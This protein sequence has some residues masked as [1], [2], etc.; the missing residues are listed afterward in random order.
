MPAT[1][2][3]IRIFISSPGDVRPERDALEAVISDDLQRTLGRQHNLYLEPLRWENLA[4]PGL[5][6]IQSQV[7][8]QM[9]AYDIFVGIFWKRFGTPTAKHESGSEEEFRDAYA[10]WEEDNDRPVMMYF[11][12]RE[13]NISLDTDP[14]K[15]MKQLQQAQKVKAFREEIGQKGL[16][17][18]YKEVD[19]FK[20]EIGRH[21][22]DAILSLLE[23][24]DFEKKAP[25]P[26]GE[27]LK[28]AQ[29]VV[30][31][32]VGQASGGE[33]KGA[34]FHHHHYYAS[35]QASDEVEESKDPMKFYLTALK[36]ECEVLPLAT[37]GGKAGTGQNITLNEVYISLG[38]KTPE[39]ESR[40]ANPEEEEKYLT[41][42]EASNQSRLVVL[43]GGP[44][45]G[46]STFVKELTANLA[47]KRLEEPTGSVPVF[48]TLRD[49]APRLGAIKE[50]LAG[51][52]EDKRRRKL[53][54]V[55]LD[56]AIA[57]LETLNALE[58]RRTGQRGLYRRQGPPGA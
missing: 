6:D 27:T 28:Q 21:L 12:E 51:L 19:E 35:S 37:L 31:I 5:G 46:K 58:A 22:H 32:H 30:N 38:T 20:I 52:Q 4:R 44:G 13:A 48:I 8:E 26:T 9:G 17:W 55:V 50:K 49:L 25:E 45:S 7:S 41:A 43:V 2:R 54:Q 14:D 10:L 57:D 29:T 40:K 42:L 34:E 33:I 39:K 15:A 47:G 24:P 11:C 36:T 3:H 56:Q 18:T 53:A 23:K 1:L 16:Y